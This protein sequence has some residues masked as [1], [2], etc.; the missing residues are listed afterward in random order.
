M[1]DI[2]V[3]DKNKILKSGLITQGGFVVEQEQ[4]RFLITSA[5]DDYKTIGIIFT[6]KN[7]NIHPKYNAQLLSQHITYIVNNHDKLVNLISL[8]NAAKTENENYQ[9]K[10]SM[11]LYLLGLLSKDSMD[12]EIIQSIIQM[13]GEK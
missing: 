11:V 2:Q 7:E 10:L 1:S 9:N 6:D 12:N 8:Y 5:G 4:D 13:L 3:I